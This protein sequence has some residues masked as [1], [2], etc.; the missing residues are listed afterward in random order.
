MT[1]DAA[2]AHSL[3]LVD[4]SPCGQEHAQLAEWLME[5]RDR[6]VLDKAFAPLTFLTTPARAIE[7]LNRALKADP[8]CILAL[9][10]QRVECNEALANDETIQC[11]RLGGPDPATSDA[12]NPDLL[13]PP[14]YGIGLLGIVNGIFGI[15]PEGHPLAGWGPIAADYEG[16][17]G[18][19][20]RFQ[21]VAEADLQQE[22]PNE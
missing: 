5:L 11:A 19:I 13:P 14:R 2:I 22:K 8:D 9:C 18:P 15:Y 6:K 21:L 3:A 4:D 17:E 7:V 10:E 20:T 16:P 12:T 1:L